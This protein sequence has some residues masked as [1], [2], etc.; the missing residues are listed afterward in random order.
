ME[1]RAGRVRGALGNTPGFYLG[2]RKDRLHFMLKGEA[3][4]V[5]SAL[6]KS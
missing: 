1:F 2:T 4:I 6:T 5:H 3:K